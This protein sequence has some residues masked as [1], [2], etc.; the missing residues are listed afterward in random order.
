[1]SVRRF[2]SALVLSVAF[3]AAGEV[4]YFAG[5]E[6]VVPQGEVVAV[7]VRA[8]AGN[9]RGGSWL[10][11]WPGATVRLS[12]SADR[13]VDGIDR[14]GALLEVNGEKFECSRGVATSGDPNT[15]AIEW[16]SDSVATILVGERNVFEVA[17]T[18][19]PKPVGKVEISGLSQPFDLVDFIIET[20][21]DSFG[22]LES[23]LD[24]EAIA[25]GR[26]W[27]YLDRESDPKTAVMG[28]QYVM[29]Q[30]GLELIYVEGA[31]TNPA[32]WKTGMTKGRL[33]PTGF[34]GY[35]RLQWFDA[36]GRELSGENYAEVNDDLGIM[37]L[38][39][40]ALGASVR[41][42]D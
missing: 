4:F 31:M 14:P 19:L 16:K 34:D 27:S 32:S 42:H 21:S 18:A 24:D 9:G 36:T 1:M 11:A 35:Y 38:T 17:S 29:A 5:R 8:G 26:R 40:P 7:E 6:A 39:F 41:F 25:S 28:G 37:K 3:A 12:F 22:R 33:K 10:I 23:G 20:D 30:V 13:F 2:L 15:V